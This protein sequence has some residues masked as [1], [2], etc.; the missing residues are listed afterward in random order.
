MGHSVR[1]QI[2]VRVEGELPPTWSTLLADLAVVAEADGT[3]LVRGELADQAALHGLLAAI[4]DLGLSL[5]SV[6]TV[7]TTLPSSR[8]D[9]PLDG[10]HPSPPGSAR[11]ALR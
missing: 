1:Y 10:G 3:T 9:R 6:E 11:R 2:R 5:I 8:A 7:A 4:R